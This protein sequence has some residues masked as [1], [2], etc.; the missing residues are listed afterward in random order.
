MLPLTYFLTKEYDILGPAIANT[1][2]ITIYNAIRIMFL[3]KKFNLFPFR[4]QSAYT[5]LL[6]GLCF[7]ICYYLFDSVHGFGGLVLRSLLF[8]I[9]YGAGVFYFKLSPDV[10]PVLQTILK[11]MG[12]GSRWVD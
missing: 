1:I 10:R 7:G 8:V 2:S 9:L 4:I 12:R 11:R 6:A 5:V 3:Y